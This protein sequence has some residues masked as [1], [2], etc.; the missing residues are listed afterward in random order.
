MKFILAT[1]CLIF[2]LTACTSLH[3]TKAEHLADKVVCIVNNPSVETVFRD[4]YERQ[5][6]AKGYDTKI[7]AKGEACSTTSTYEATYGFHWGVYLAS[8]ELKIFYQGVEVGKSIYHA[9]Y[10]SPAKHGRV[11][12]KIEKMID[13]LLP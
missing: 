9:P 6:R 8:A 2:P 13:E 4:A 10:V 5:I 3:T 12:G 7:I 1:A 11:E